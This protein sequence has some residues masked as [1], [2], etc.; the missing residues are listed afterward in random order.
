[1]TSAPVVFCRACARE[2]QVGPPPGSDNP[3][4]AKRRLLK[5]CP[6]K[7][8]SRYELYQGLTDTLPCDLGYRAGLIVGEGVRGQ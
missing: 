4:R 7:H 3:E 5:R 2:E 8:G 1:M 6:Y